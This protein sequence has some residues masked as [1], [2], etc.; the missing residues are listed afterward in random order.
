MYLS[1]KARASLGRVVEQFKAGDLSPIARVVRIQR[2]N[3]DELPS[4]R[5]S[6]SNR[7]MAYIQTGDVDVRGFNQWKQAGRYVKA[8]ERAAYILAHIYKDVEDEHTGEVRKVLVTFKG[9]PVYG[10]SQTDGEALEQPDYAPAMLPPLAGVAERLHIDVTYTPL[11][12]DRLGD[13]DLQGQRI[14]LGT[15]D[16][17]TF[18]HELA[19]AAHARLDGKLK[20]GQDAEQETIAE[21]TATVLMHLYGYGDRTGNCWQYVEQYA[22]DP[23]TAIS[24]ALKKV[25]AVLEV[26]GV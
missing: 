13:C 11:P 21:F 25:E 12:P 10:Y 8:D 6:L 26:L 3:G 16:P 4:E 17:G 24:K 2:E 9:V 14:N 19:H 22:K 5:W 7:I 18:F 1:E 15:Y 20:G 23:L